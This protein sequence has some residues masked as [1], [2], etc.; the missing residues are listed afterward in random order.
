MIFKRRDK[1][2]YMIQFKEMF[3]PKKGWR[4]AI[5]YFA[6]RIKRL[7]DTPHKITLGLTCGI[8]TSFLPIFG[9]H[10]FIAGL[11]AYLFKG[12]ILASIFGTFFGN[13]LTF[14]IIAT[15]SVNFG[16]FILGQNLSDFQSLFDNSVK[17]FDAIWLGLKA[18]FGVGVSDWGLVIEFGS[19]IF[20]PYLIG[21]IFLGS[22]TAAFSYFILHPILVAYQKS[23]RKKK[24]KKMKINRQFK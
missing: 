21:G 10:F 3:I 23:R 13:P 15:L 6:H 17:V 14:P 12:N 7:P 4:R 8:F 11:L 24:L 1:V 18:I 20:F 22:S 19:E 5:E 9:F 2:S 16:Q